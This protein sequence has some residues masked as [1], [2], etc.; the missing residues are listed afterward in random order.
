ML[1]TG[2]EKPAEQ[3]LEH[4]TEEWLRIIFTLVGC[5]GCLRYQAGE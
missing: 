1:R 4:C 2:D 3:A 5:N